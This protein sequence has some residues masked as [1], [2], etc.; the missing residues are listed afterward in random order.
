[1]TVDYK[2]PT[3]NLLNLLTKKRNVAGIEISDSMVR[4]T[5]FRS[6]KKKGSTEHLDQEELILIEEPIS[7]NIIADG[8]V[9]DVE[10]L[11]KTLRDI[12]NR[13]KL[14]T[15][16]AI[17]A[18]PDDK[19]YSKIFSFPK[20]VDGTRLTEAMR[21]AIGFQLPMKTEDTYL[22]WE[23]TSG[24]ATTNEI[25]LSTIPRAVADGYVNALEKAGIRIIALESHLAS[26]ARTV[27][28]TPGITTLF[29]KKTPDGATVFALKDGILRF[30]RTLPLRFVS[31]K[32]RLSEIE[33]I[34]ISITA[35]ISGDVIVQEL[36][37]AT[38]RDE[39]ADRAEIT[40]PKS[41]W[42]VA[43]GATIRSKMPEGTDNLISLLPIG[44]EEAYAYQRVTSFT[45]LIR[46][47]TIGVSMFFIVAYIATYFF[48]YSL[49]QNKVGQ[50]TTL[51]GSIISS[52][53]IEKEQQ[54]S[55]IN[56]ITETGA[57]FL[58]KTP[59]W[60]TVFEELTK[61]TPDGIIISRFSAPIFN[62]K[63]F[64]TGTAT[65]RVTLNDYKKVIQ[66]SSLFTD[67][68][69]PIT[70]LEMKEKIPFTISFRLKDPSK[71]YYK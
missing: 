50:V 48:I 57:W 67:I 36:D 34:R 24:G 65:N 45:L 1:M 35:E 33:K 20:S 13:A 12:W 56:S 8:V 30:S 21:L 14:D 9:I 70:N 29:S 71:L 43:L 39:Y 17:V 63:M 60:S 54:I 47:L 40:N 25:L 7:A 58:D 52:E 41:K 19:I 42:F 68:E 11:S 61:I 15:D 2:L 46:N 69:L 28:L 44:T 3:M 32:A 22:D 6:R 18:I 55:D 64:F 10:L 23:R 31:E 37:D 16:Y 59:I 5:L 38:I 66:G 49:L 27:K 26:I 51:S 4:I 62:E 53:I